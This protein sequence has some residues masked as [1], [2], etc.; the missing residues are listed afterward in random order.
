MV[1]P[2]TKRQRTRTALIAA[3]QALI[4]EGGLSAVTLDAVAARVGVTK[5]AI[6]S[7]FRGKAELVWAAAEPLRPG[8]DPPILAGQPIE[9]A[10]VTARALMALLPTAGRQAEFMAELQAQVRADPELRARQAAQQHALFDLMAERLQ[11]GFGDLLVLPPRTVGLTIQ[12][13]ILGFI[14]QWERTPEEVT[15]DVVTAAFEALARGA[16]RQPN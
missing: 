16:T 6:Y 2:L 12:A 13:L 14:A 10:R 1:K 11:A 7:S 15:E 9:Q 8:L 5:G 4:E 3:A